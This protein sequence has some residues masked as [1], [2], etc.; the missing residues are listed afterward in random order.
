MA[1]GQ[2]ILH[3]FQGDEVYSISTASW[4][5]IPEEAGI[6]VCFRVTTDPEPIRSL[7]DTV[8]LRAHPDAEVGILVPGIDLETLVGQRFTV[9]DAYSQALGD[10]VAALAYCEHQDLNDNE[11]HILGRQG[12]RLHVHWTARTSDV[13]FYDRTT[14]D[15]RVE[16]EAWF[17]L[18]A[19]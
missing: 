18:N 3:R 1:L 8:D 17:R 9:P 10:Y 11:V 12:S 2:F 6:L 14:P 13:N 4:W 7:P 16:I 15:T 5:T 19:E